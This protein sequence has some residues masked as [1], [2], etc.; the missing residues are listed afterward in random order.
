MKILFVRP[1]S[2]PEH[3]GNRCLATVDVEFNDHLRLYGLRLLQMR[4]GQHRL[5]APQAGRRRTAS[6]SPETARSLTDMA[7][8]E[9]EG[10][11][12]VNQ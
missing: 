5:F 4:D 10:G 9:F 1:L 8:R 11:G 6:F 2:E 12:H 3:D 7:L